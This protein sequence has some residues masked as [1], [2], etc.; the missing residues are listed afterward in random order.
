MKKIIAALLLA[1]PV[2]AFGQEVN[3]STGSYTGCGGFLVDSGNTA[4]DYTPNENYTFLICAEE[5]EEVINLYWN[6]CDLGEGDQISIYDGVDDTAPLIGTYTGFDLQAQDIYNS[7]DNTTGCLFLVFTSDAE[8]NGNFTA[9]ISCGYPCE[10][11]FAILEGQDEIPLLICPGDE[12]NFDASPSTV[13]EGFELT[14]WEWDY[15]D[16]EVETFTDGPTASHTYD[17]PGAYKVQL[18]LTDNNECENN[19]LTDYLIL[20][21][22]DPDFT[23]TSVDVEICVGQEVDLTGVVNGITW[24]GTPD[25]NLGGELF[26]PDD[27]EQCF[28]STITYQAFAP[29][30][31]VEQP[32]DIDDIF[33]NFEHS[34]MGDLTISIICPSGQSMALHQQGGG[35]TWLGEPVDDD[36][37]PNAQGVGYDYWWAP[38]ATLGTWADES[39]GFT[40]LPSDTYSSAQPWTLLE[41]CPLNGDWTI[42]ICDSWGSDNGF[43]FDW[44]IN[45]D[46]EL[47]P[48]PIVFTPQ[49]GPECDSTSWAGPSIIETSADCN[50]ITIQP[51]SSGQEQYV[52][53]A[54]NNH[55]CTY[56]QT[57]NVIITQGPIAAT[58]DVLYWCGSAISLDGQ[59][60]NPE[61]GTVYEYSW[62]N[63]GLLS[64]PNVANP[65]LGNLDDETVFTLTVNPLGA[66]ECASTSS[67][68]VAIP[69]EPIIF[70]QDTIIGC[71]GEEFLLV[72]PDQSPDWDYNFVWVNLDDEDQPL[73]QQQGIAVGDPGT[74]QLTISMV[75]PCNYVIQEEIEVIMEV[76]ELGDIPNVI[77]PN[78]DA[79]NDF[80]R[81][82]GLEYFSGSSLLVYNRWGAL[83]YESDNYKSNWSP[84]EDEASEGTY[85]FILTVN[86]PEGPEEF[87][88]ELTIL[89]K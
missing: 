71:F 7:V 38:D 20:V 81:I 29:N 26:I 28:E 35:G 87:T 10:R 43:I 21:S 62:D 56:E 22:T 65:Q 55:G 68:L 89:R 45:F 36:G 18:G 58:S 39:G 67:V 46:P 60:T 72:A 27:Q 52:Y 24:D 79:D 51:T 6:L 11:P 30:Q 49:F 31:V 25:A 73:P 88:G 76:C 74:Y 50:D 53:T 61:V 82:E 86:F 5:P 34:F 40:T 44:A 15:G 78:G 84:T 37:Q 4:G 57:V 14:E 3:I 69:D 48:E 1:M 75:D 8:D 63:G 13:A 83:I 85:Y 42:E 47:F 32:E 17:V 59:I 23:G 12:V 33:V 64:D 41:G 70:P 16:G 19:N 66:P 54:T 77:T 9:E 80:F 2:L